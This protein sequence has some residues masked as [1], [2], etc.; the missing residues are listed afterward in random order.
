MIARKWRIKKLNG[1]KEVRG[2]G[3]TGMREQERKGHQ[4]IEEEKIRVG[5]EKY[6][7]EREIKQGFKRWIG[8]QKLESKGREMRKEGRK[9][10][11]GHVREK[12]KKEGGQKK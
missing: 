2:K 7:K 10:M 8:G 12:K 11:E 4:N 1:E 6:E 3:E 9:W 5:K